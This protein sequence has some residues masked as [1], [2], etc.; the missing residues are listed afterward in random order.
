MR[1]P[2]CGLPARVQELIVY[3]VFQVKHLDKKEDI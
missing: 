3:I 2:G 1:L